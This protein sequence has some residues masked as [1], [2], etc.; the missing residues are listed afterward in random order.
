MPALNRL[1]PCRRSEQQ[2][3]DMRAVHVGVGH[4]DDLVIAQLVRRLNS[5]RP[6]PVPSAVISVPIASTTASGRNAPARCS[7][8]CRA[9]AARSGFLPVCVPAWPSRRPKSPS[10]MNNSDPSGSFLA[11]RG[12]LAGQVRHVHAVLRL[13]PSRLAR[14]SPRASAARPDL[15]DDLFGLGGFSLE[16][17]S[18]LPDRASTAGAPPGLRPACPWSGSRTRIGTFTDSTAG[19]PSR[20][21]S[22]VARTFSPSSR[23]RCLGRSS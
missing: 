8:S 23:C 20:A 21:S 1:L 9:A 15:A 6:I 11:I 13:A 16:P 19:Q 2:R 14:R 3:A 12:Q 18:Q 5:S 17:L 4:D 10:T 7:G 22:P